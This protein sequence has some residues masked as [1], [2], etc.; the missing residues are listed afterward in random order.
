M[1]KLAKPND[2]PPKA[3]LDCISKIRKKELKD[4]LLALKDLISEATVEFDSKVTTG[5][6]HTVIREPLVNSNVTAKELMDVYNFRMVKKGSPGRKYYDRIFV[7]A[8]K[9][10]C[11]LC[12]HR[13][14]TTLDHYLPKAHYPRL[15]VEPINLIPSCYACNIDKK[16]TYPTKPN[17]ETLHPYY[18]DIENVLWLKAVVIEKQPISI[19]FIVEGPVSWSKN[20]SERVKFH[21]ESFDLKKLYTTQAARELSGVKFQFT[22]IF[23]K[24][25]SNS[26]KEHLLDAA[27]SRSKDN[28]NSW[29]A[30]LYN[31]LA[32]SNWFCN[33][34]VLM[35]D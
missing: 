18:D 28:I 13:D 22:S 27:K 12:S 34:G 10:L 16:S 24:S 35:I 9:G 7:S 8:P 20:F 33:G 2:I 4:R 5:Q 3:F 1:R 15:S 32:N 19:D 30:A 14:V 17:E 26:L 31:G 21:F 29:Q 25:G 11:P 23:N 6:L